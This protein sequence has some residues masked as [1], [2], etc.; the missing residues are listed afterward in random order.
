MDL[1]EPD[2][3]SVYTGM[4]RISVPRCSLAPSLEIAIRMGYSA[5]AVRLSRPSFRSFQRE[6]GRRNKGGQAIQQIAIF[7]SLPPS[8]LPY[9]S[10][11]ISCAAKSYCYTVNWAFSS[12]PKVLAKG[13]RGLLALV[14]SSRHDVP[15]T[16]FRTSSGLALQF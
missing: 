6:R 9:R 1:A 4:N 14:E 13:S 15:S 7:T 16:P 2:Y 8:L 3:L 11:G 12:F 10:Q 5:D